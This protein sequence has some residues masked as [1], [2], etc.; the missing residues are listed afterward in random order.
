[1]QITC[2]YSNSHLWEHLI[3]LEQMWRLSRNAYCISGEDMPVSSKNFLLLH[4]NCLWFFATNGCKFTSRD[5]LEL[6]VVILYDHQELGLLGNISGWF[7]VICSLSVWAMYALS[8]QLFMT[9]TFISLFMVICGSWLQTNKP[10]H[11]F[12]ETC[13]DL[14]HSYVKLELNRKHKKPK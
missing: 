6:G 11:G 1:M 7:I 8:M 14:Q 3:A 12:M 2:V 10:G 9:A 4:P 13:W 5:E